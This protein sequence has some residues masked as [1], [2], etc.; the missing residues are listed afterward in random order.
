MIP[1]DVDALLA[2]TH[3]KSPSAGVTRVTGVTPSVIPSNHAAQEPLTAVTHA[4]PV[5]SNKGNTPGAGA[6]DAEAVTSVTRIPPALGNGLI[7]QQGIDIEGFRKSV[8]SVTPV[9]QKKE[10]V[11][12]LETPASTWRCYCCHGTR[13]WK[14]IAGV[15]I[16]ARCHP[17]G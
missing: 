7:V 12:T 17:P 10:Y 8:T 13:R 11:V 6:P 1:H 2:K 9:T 3:R 15:L 4:D 16:C 14:S 5:Q